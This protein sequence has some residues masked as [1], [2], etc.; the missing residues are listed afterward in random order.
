MQDFVEVYN[1]TEAKR[2]A[3]GAGVDNAA[4]EELPPDLGSPEAADFIGGP[5]AAGTAGMGTG[6]GSTKPPAF[7]PFDLR[8]FDVDAA[9]VSSASSGAVQSAGHQLRLRSPCSGGV[10]MD[11]AV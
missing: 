2:M 11:G 9:A 3:L 1:A 6:A 8:A 7:V 10:E 5:D 4:D